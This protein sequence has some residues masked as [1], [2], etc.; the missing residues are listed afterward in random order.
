MCLTQQSNDGATIRA[1]SAAI[2]GRLTIFMLLVLVAFACDEDDAEPP[3]DAEV[4]Q[5]IDAI[6]DAEI[7]ACVPL[8]ESCDG[9]DNDCDEVAD[10]GL[11]LGQVCQ[12]L[13][14]D[15]TQ[16]GQWA[17]GDDGEVICAVEPIEELCNEL[18]D[19]CDGLIDEDCPSD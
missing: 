11:P 2:M 7:D 4:D 16:T 19:D 13:T 18:D 17:C 9:L 14:A 5:A 1:L 10:E 12:I 8:E 3:V 15:C 6:V